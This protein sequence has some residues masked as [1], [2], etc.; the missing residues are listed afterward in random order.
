MWICLVNDEIVG[1]FVKGCAHQRAAAVAEL[2]ID[3][4]HLIAHAAR[5][6]YSKQH[7]TSLI[8]HLLAGRPYIESTGTIAGLSIPL[9]AYKYPITIEQQRSRIQSL[10]CEAGVQRE[11]VKD[12]LQLVA[13]GATDIPMNRITCGGVIER[14]NRARFDHRLAQIAQIVLKSYADA[15]GA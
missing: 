3:Y 14:L 9:G 13:C 12:V 4:E 11:I 15:E 1:N 8:G 5:T 10:G 6:H 7:R 2:P